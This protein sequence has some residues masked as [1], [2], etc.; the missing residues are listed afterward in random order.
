MLFLL[1]L[2]LPVQLEGMEVKG[3]SLFFLPYKMATTDTLRYC[4]LATVEF[5]VTFR[6]LCF[7]V[8]SHL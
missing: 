7:A 1:V 4:P 3:Y 6:I 8:I 2:I 5:L